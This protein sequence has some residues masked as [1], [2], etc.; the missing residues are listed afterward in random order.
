MA[1]TETEHQ[2]DAVHAGEHAEDEHH[3]TPR[4]YVEV[5]LVL[6]VLTAMEVAAS[7]IELGGAFV[8]L[9][10]VLMATKFVLVAG[11]FM[12]LRYDTRLYTRVMASGLTLAFSLYL[13]VLVVFA[14]EGG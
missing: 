8:P 6:A 4:Q 7:F 13:I 3:P 1:A 11:W 12:H 2:T 10:V 5:A 14:G 9:L